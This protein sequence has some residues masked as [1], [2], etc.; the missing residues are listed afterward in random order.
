MTVHFGYCNNQHKP[1]MFRAEWAGWARWNGTDFGYLGKYCGHPHWHI[2]AVDSLRDDA[3]IDAAAELL[4]VLKDEE[5]GM[6]PQDFSAPLVEPETI[7][8]LISNRKLSRIHFHSAASW[9]E[10]PSR[11][12][13]VHSPKVEGEIQLWIGKTLTYVVRELARLKT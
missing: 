13:H 10:H 4:A 2:D 5:Q 9:W 7:R 3:S 12:V 11:D 8:E 1:Q 6:E